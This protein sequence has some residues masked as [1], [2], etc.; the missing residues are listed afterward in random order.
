MAVINHNACNLGG[1][2]D[3]NI[4]LM[5]YRACGITEVKSGPLANKNKKFTLS[6]CRFFCSLLPES[7]SVTMTPFGIWKTV[8]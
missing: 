4:I 7:I 6:L 1:R 8:N 3:K 2:G 5:D